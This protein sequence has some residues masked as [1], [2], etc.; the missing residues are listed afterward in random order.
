MSSL[1]ACH[2]GEED[3]SRNSEVS[4]KAQVGQMGVTGISG[5]VRIVRRLGIGARLRNIAREQMFSL[6]EW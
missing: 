3:A 6:V 2:I 5:N 4:R 1:K